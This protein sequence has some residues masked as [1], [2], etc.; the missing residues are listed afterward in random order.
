MG[1]TDFIMCEENQESVM[2]KEFEAL[3][4]ST[5]H[6]LCKLSYAIW[7]K[8]DLEEIRHKFQKKSIE[9]ILKAL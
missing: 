4:I 8:T 9:N 7:R 2:S 3:L 5:I 1:D 6:H